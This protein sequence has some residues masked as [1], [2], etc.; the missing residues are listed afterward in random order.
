[1]YMT[2]VCFMS[3][4]VI[5]WGSDTPNIKEIREREIIIINR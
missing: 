4:V 3:V 5:V 1:M 2:H